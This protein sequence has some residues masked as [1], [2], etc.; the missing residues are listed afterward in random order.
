MQNTGHWLTRVQDIVPN[1][2]LDQPPATVPMLPCLS[3]VHRYMYIFSSQFSFRPCRGLVS[4]LYH[5]PLCY[6]AVYYCIAVF[7]SRVPLLDDCVLS[8]C[9]L[10]TGAKR[11]HSFLLVRVQLVHTESP[12]HAG[13][14][15]MRSP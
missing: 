10:S 3:G 15:H 9:R 12:A 1:P 2:V 7:V 11:G 13:P 8:R 14:V 6:C 5:S 4:A